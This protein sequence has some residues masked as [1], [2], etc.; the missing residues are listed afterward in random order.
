MDMIVPWKRSAGGSQCW[1][2]PATLWVDGEAGH[3]VEMALPA[4]RARWTDV[5]GLGRERSPACRSCL[6]MTIAERLYR[7]MGG[8]VLVTRGR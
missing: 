5:E 7:D 1:W 4:R 2:V 6:A 3:F 8:V